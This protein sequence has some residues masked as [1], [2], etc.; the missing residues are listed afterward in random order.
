MKSTT[1][2]IDFGIANTLLIAFNN[3]DIFYTVKSAPRT[4]Q[5]KLIKSNNNP[6]GILDAYIYKTALYVINLAFKHHAKVIQMEDLSCT[7]FTRNLFYF[8]LQR[9]IQNLAEERSLLVRYVNRD[10]SSQKC[11]RCGYIDKGNRITRDVFLCK[12]CG[13]SINADCNAAINISEI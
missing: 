6:Y 11:S 1:M 5:G 8:E 3:T 4:R 9:A 13:F 12:R 10:F 7:S 2:G